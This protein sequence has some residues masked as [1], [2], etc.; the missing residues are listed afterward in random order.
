MSNIDIPED[1]RRKYLER[2]K[3]DFENCQKAAEE[4]DFEVLARVGH[5]IKGNASTFGFEDL[6]AIAIQME[7][8]AL[9][10]DSQK[11]TTALKKFSDFLSRTH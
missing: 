3:T 7:E 1:V 2:R 4:N 11:V 10:R 8:G 5:Q 9:T 6:S